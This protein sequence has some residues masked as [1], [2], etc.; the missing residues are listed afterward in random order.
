MNTTS[1]NVAATILNQLGGNKFKAMTGSFDIF[2][3]ESA[4]V[5]KLRKNKS[6]AKY[7]RIE[8]NMNDTY[9]MIFRTEHKPTYSFPVIEKIEGVYADMLRT[10]FTKVTGL[11]TSL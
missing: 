7:L 9:T 3:D 1:T 11:E 10:I 6:K 5:M 8:L 2:S 4:L